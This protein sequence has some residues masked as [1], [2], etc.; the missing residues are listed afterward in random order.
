MP[1]RTCLKKVKVTPCW[2]SSEGGL[3]RDLYVLTGSYLLFPL[4]LLPE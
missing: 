2:F 4:V 1:F 3:I